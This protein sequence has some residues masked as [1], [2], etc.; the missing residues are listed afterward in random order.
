M[1]P[2]NRCPTGK[3]RH[4]DRDTARR[5]LGDARATADERRD[6]K[7]PRHT[8]RCPICAGFHVTSQSRTQYLMWPGR[9]R[10]RP[11]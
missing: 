6:R 3:V 5:A 2:T 1:D 8:Y 9:T 4:P 10:R 7:T 11:A